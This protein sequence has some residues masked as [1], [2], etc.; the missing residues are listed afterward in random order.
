[1]GLATLHGYP[2]V[3]GPSAT[4]S[5]ETNHLGKQ[6]NIVKN[7][8]IGQAELI[9]KM[10]LHYQLKLKTQ[11]VM[12]HRFTNKTQIKRYFYPNLVF[13]IDFVSQA[14][15]NISSCSSTTSSSSRG[16]SITWT[17]DLLSSKL[18]PEREDW[19][20][21]SGDLDPESTGRQSRDV[22]CGLTELWSGWRYLVRWNDIH[23]TVNN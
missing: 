23:G 12:Y 13:W 4:W 11:R 18:N 21:T 17:Q 8:N 10:L 5:D 6:Y 9:F 3:H 7:K 2:G 15:L 16:T 19:V 20:T 1:M 22:T 14:R